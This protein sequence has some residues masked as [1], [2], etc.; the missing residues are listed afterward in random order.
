MNFAAK[1]FL[2]LAAFFLVA[3]IGLET[4]PV[5]V[6]TDPSP[7]ARYAGTAPWT[8]AGVRPG[9]N[10]EAV[11]ARLGPP[12]RDNREGARRVVRWT[13]PEEIGITATA[14]GEVVDVLGASLSAGGERIL[15]RGFEGDSVETILGSA[16]IERHYGPSGSGVISLGM[17]ERGRTLRYDNAGVAFEVGVNEGRVSYV[18]ALKPGTK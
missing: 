15:D 9:D 12:A 14:T 6:L 13:G 8:V 17:K 18:R 1:F 16:R 10:V 4:M 2:G 3:S 5:R 7:Y 11:I